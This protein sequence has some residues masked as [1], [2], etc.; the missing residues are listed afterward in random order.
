MLQN[1]TM[2]DLYY[3]CFQ[4][5]WIFGRFH[6][7]VPVGDW[8]TGAGLQLVHVYYSRREPTAVFDLFTN[9]LGGRGS[10]LRIPGTPH[11]NI[12]AT[13]HFYCATPPMGYRRHPAYDEKNNYLG[14][15]LCLISP[16]LLLG[17]LQTVAWVAC[18]TYNAEYHGCK[19]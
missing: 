16:F 15:F 11:Q 9:V 8:H 14:I 5:F 13:I 2:V 17:G 3:R 12:R 6:C 7:L 10:I 4:I 18:H 1:T 19:R